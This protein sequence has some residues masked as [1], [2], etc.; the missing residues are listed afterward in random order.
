VSEIRT[1]DEVRV[2]ARHSCRGE[3]ITNAMK[4]REMKQGYG[5]SGEEWTDGL[6]TELVVI[7]LRKSSFLCLL[8]V[9]LCTDS[10]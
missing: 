8:N 3:N 4:S 5:A 6:G 9:K 7:S 10:L 1:D 2:E